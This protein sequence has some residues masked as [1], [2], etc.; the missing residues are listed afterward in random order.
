MALEE[1]ASDNMSSTPEVLNTQEEDKLLVHDRKY[2]DSLEA[3]NLSAAL[4]YAMV[5]ISVSEMN[6]DLEP[7]SELMEIASEATSKH[8]TY[9]RLNQRSAGIIP[10]ILAGLNTSPTTAG[11]P[12]EAAKPL[13]SATAA[14]PPP[15][16]TGADGKAATATNVK[17]LGAIPKKNSDREARTPGCKR[18]GCLRQ[19]P[20]QSQSCG[21]P[22][23]DEQASYCR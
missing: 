19:R 6:I 22:L 18:D 21:G 3:S 9:E 17:D 7:E 14:S 11:S 15:T 10:P 5:Q 1:P 2:E 8:D 20:G 13:T 16:A 4:D 23:R 12:T